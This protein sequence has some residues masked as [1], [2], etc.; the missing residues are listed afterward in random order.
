MNAFEELLRIAAGERDC[1]TASPGDDR[2]E[3]IFRLAERHCILGPL[4]GGIA[5]LPQE[6]R[7]PRPLWL[8]WL[9]SVDKIEKNNER[10]KARLAELCGMV[11]DAGMKCCLLKGLSTSLLYPGQSPRQCGDIDLWVDGCRKDVVAFAKARCEVGEVVYH[12]ADARFFDDVEVELHFTPTWMFNPFLNCRLQ[13]WFESRKGEMMSNRSEQLGCAVPTPYFNIVYSVIHIFRHVLDEGIGLRQMMDLFYIL[14]AASE[15][16]RTAAMKTLS[17]LGLGKFCGQL[18]YVLQEA[19]ALDSE[20]MLATPDPVR[21]RELYRDVLH[22][23]NFG[24]MDPRNRP[25]EGE[26][27]L[28]R[29]FRKTRLQMRLFLLFPRELFWAPSFKLWQ[30]LWRRRNGWL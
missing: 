25:A 16:D 11:S 13:R 17:G 29:F 24:S 15:E 12:H 14:P 23:G 28:G 4:A 21:G 6:Q 3:K 5:R 30:Y 7:P 2:W 22:G 27:R 8:R 1:F 10:M 26:G 18:M 9:Y 20:Y 19:F